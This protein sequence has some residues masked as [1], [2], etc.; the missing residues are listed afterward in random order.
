MTQALEKQDCSDSIHRQ[1][2]SALR[3]LI[4]AVRRSQSGSVPRKGESMLQRGIE[5]R[6]GRF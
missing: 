5:R 6:E 2:F 1:I 3:S 4:V